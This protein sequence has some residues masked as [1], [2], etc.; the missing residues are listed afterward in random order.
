MCSRRIGHRS[1]TAPIEVRHFTR[2]KHNE[3]AA[4]AKPFDGSAQ[5]AA[6]LRSRGVFER[7]YKKDFFAQGGRSGEHAVRNDA[8]ISPDFG[9]QVNEDKSFQQAKGMVGDNE[10]GAG[11][12]DARG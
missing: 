11:G 2:G 3:E 12:G 7:V 8:E 4:A 10:C 1:F 6:V 5:A 9:E